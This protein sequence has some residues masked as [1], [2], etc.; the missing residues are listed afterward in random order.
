MFRVIVVNT[1]DRA[2]EE[3]AVLNGTYASEAEARSAYIEA[4][5]TLGHDKRYDIRLIVQ[6][7]VRINRIECRGALPV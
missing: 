2:D 6:G 5:T 7:A 4:I 3:A 1:Q